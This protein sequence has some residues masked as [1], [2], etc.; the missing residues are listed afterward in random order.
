[1]VVLFLIYGVGS[2]FCFWLFLMIFFCRVNVG[3][4]LVEEWVL[5]IGLYV[6]VDIYCECCKIILGWKYVSIIFWI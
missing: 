4:G 6:V 1:M 2:E 3:C 5:L